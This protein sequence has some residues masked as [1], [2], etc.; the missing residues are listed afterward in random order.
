MLKVFFILANGHEI[1]RDRGDK[2]AQICFGVDCCFER[3]VLEK[4]G[5]PI[6]PGEATEITQHLFVGLPVINFIK[7][8]SA[9]VCCH[10]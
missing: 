9:S 4:S 5:H 8:Y 10:N 2:M 7:G 3:C 1:R 6:I